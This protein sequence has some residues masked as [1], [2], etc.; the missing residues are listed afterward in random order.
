MEL[1]DVLKRKNL[2]QRDLA[3]KL[4]VHETTVSKWK[5]QGLP[6]SRV[7]EVAEAV[8]VDPDDLRPDDSKAGQYVESKDDVADWHKCV[9][10]S[11]MH[12]ISKQVLGTLATFLDER[13]WVSTFTT[14]ALADKTGWSET[15]I[16]E[17]WQEVADS[18][19]VERIGHPNVEWVYR[20]KFPDDI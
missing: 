13:A 15:D 10:Q 20:L 17:H 2:R 4:G 6:D 7:E 5:R 8:G 16:R 11:D 1:E 19:F 3:D 9:S 14:A 18:P 12:P